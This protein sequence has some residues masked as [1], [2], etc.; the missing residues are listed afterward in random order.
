M[1]E[2]LDTFT[3]PGAIALIPFLGSGVM[4]RACYQKGI[5][6]F[7]WE[8]TEVLRDQFLLKVEEDMLA[9]VKEHKG[10]SN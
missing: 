5:K 2:L 9:K 3:F 1:E 8:L 4:L 6:G 10:D 7:G